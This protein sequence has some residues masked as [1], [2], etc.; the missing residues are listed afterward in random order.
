MVRLI[1][2]LKNG[3]CSYILWMIHTWVMRKG[4]DGIESKFEGICIIILG[5]NN[6]YRVGEYSKVRK[7]DSNWVETYHPY[8]VLYK[9]VCG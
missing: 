5:Y 3:F 9:P 6:D 2:K 4:I 8:V 1:L 7:K